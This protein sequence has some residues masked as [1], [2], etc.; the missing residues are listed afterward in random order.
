MRY[1]SS[2]IKLCACATTWNQRTI[3]QHLLSTFFIAC[4]IRNPWHVLLAFF[5]VLCPNL[6]SN[7]SVLYENEVIS[8]NP[9]AYYRLNET[10]GTTASDAVGT[11][12]ASYG[13]GMILGEAG[14]RPLEFPGL[15][16]GNKA[17]QGNNNNFNSGITI[18]TSLGMSSNQ[19]SVTE[20]FKITEEQLSTSS[21]MLFY[22]SASYG[23]GFGSANE[24]HV[25]LT[26]SGDLGIF[27][28]DG[29]YAFGSV[30][31]DD[32][33]WHHMAFTW[34]NKGQACVY[35]DGNE[36]LSVADNGNSFNFSYAILAGR[37]SRYSANYPEGIER[38]FG[39]MLDEIALFNR[40]LTPNEIYQQY[41]VA[42]PEP[43]TFVLLVVVALGLTAHVWRQQKRIA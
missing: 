38:V 42:V 9:I 13:S 43:S 21:G 24:L 6:R 4:S 22:G 35:L 7:A 5:V 16:T 19:G 12:S 29:V 20:W 26:N 41:A 14:P 30:K 2:I 15:E 1:L 25:H 39:G 32:G 37:P 40:T 18:P 33:K 8:Q 3:F 17:I 34:H 11:H 31:V 36:I 27:V 23:D 28:T 10:I